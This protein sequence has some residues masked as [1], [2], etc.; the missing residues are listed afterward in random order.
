MLLGF[1][2]SPDSSQHKHTLKLAIEACNWS[3]IFK[4]VSNRSD[5]Q[6]NNKGIDKPIFP[7]G[8]S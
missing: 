8:V 2:F 5:V 3:K 1:I 7:K 4:D 6:C